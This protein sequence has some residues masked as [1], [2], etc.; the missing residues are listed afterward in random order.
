MPSQTLSQLFI[1]HQP[2]STM[3]TLKAPKK[4][5]AEKTHIAELEQRIAEQS[6]TIGVLI[7]LYR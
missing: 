1:N 6:K 7:L 4:L 2:S 5:S 3:P